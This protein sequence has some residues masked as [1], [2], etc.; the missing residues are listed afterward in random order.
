[1]EYMKKKYI[2]KKIYK[3]INFPHTV[4]KYMLKK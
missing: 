1:M 2:E 4:K 3:K